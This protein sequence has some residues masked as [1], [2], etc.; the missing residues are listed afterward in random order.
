MAWKPAVSRAAFARSRDCAS[1]Y[2]PTITRTRL[3][4]TGTMRVALKPFSFRRRTR[5]LA[6]IS[7][8]PITCQN[9]A[10]RSIGLRG[11]GGGN[12]ET[13]WLS[14]TIRAGGGGGG[15]GGGATNFFALAG[16]G[17]GPSPPRRAPRRLLLCVAPPAARRLPPP[18]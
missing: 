8:A 4:W 12:A 6:G 9:D 18:I 11:F 14:E 17:G 3:S 5:E 16:S 2:G 1:L 13:S 15:G 7:L 10:G